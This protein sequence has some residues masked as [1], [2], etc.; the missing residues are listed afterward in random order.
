MEWVLKSSTEGSLM[1]VYFKVKVG[2]MKAPQQ[3]FN[4]S[5]VRIYYQPSNKGVLLLWNTFIFWLIGT[6]FKVL[7]VHLAIHIASEPRS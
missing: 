5:Q 2:Q 6:R 1:Y 3:L 7:C 4:G